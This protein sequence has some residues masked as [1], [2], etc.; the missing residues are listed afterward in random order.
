MVKVLST[1]DSCGLNYFFGVK[2]DKPAAGDEVR[3]R[4]AEKLSRDGAY[5]CPDVRPLETGI[6]RYGQ[7]G[8]A[9]RMK[10]VL[11][12]WRG[13]RTVTTGNRRYSLRSTISYRR[14]ATMHAF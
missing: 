5:I 9:C 12:Q 2:F 3:K 7:S 11:P 4:I 14:R 8:S 6:T 10:V 1:C 13:P